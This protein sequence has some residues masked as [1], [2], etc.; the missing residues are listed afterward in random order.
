VAPFFLGEINAMRLGW[1]LLPA[2]M[3]TTACSTGGQAVATGQVEIPPAQA[4]T[5]LTEGQLMNA[6]Y[7]SPDWGTFQLTDG[8]Y[9]RPTPS[10]GGTPAGYLTVLVPPILR[11]DLDGD[12]HQD[13][14]VL[15]A[16]QNGGTGVFV[17]LT[18]VLNRERLPFDA[19]TVSLGDRVIMEAGHIQDGVIILDLRVH[20]P[21]DAMCCPSQLETWR[22]RLEGSRLVRLP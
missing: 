19:D 10:A 16:T 12:G 1:L 2:L 3:L 11:G 18:A 9:Y 6:L 21:N 5:G 7:R 15:L 14:A 4:S 22:F 17:E 20:G 8:T 13:A